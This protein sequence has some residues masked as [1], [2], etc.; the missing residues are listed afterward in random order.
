MAKFIPQKQDKEVI[1]IR[2]TSDLLKSIDENAGKA[3]LSRN[4]FVN[5]CI[6]F[7]LQNIEFEN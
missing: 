6:I 2:L 3:D 5:Q 1:S 7:A 4:E